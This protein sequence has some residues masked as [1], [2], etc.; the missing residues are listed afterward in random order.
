MEE[1]KQYGKLTVLKMDTERDKYGRIKWICKCD[2][3][4]IKSIS[5]ADLR[6]GNTSSCGCKNGI[7]KGE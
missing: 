2:C 4:N 7:S 5:G 1:G 3:G 6:S